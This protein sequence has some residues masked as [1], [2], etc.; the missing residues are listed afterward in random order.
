MILRLRGRSHPV[1]LLFALKY[2]M[3]AFLSV[4]P[5]L[6]GKKQTTI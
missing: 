6:S 4:T 2:R 1:V 3:N 5:G